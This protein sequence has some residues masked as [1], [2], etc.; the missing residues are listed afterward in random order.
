MRANAGKKF[1]CRHKFDFLKNGDFY[2]NGYG[3]RYLRRHEIL[4]IMS[5]QEYDSTDE[6]DEEYE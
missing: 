5:D 4:E 1:S 3:V 6:Y 2:N